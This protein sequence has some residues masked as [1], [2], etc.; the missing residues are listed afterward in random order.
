[1]NHITEEQVIE[2]AERLNLPS[3]PGPDQM[4]AIADELEST[5]GWVAVVWD[6][7]RI[8]DRL[9]NKR[10]VREREK[11]REEAKCALRYCVDCGAAIYRKRAI[12]CP[13]CAQRRHNRLSHGER[14]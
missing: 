10:A 3:K 8:G 1:M 14:A 11:K 9:R 5:Y 12:R 7:G 6:G 13:R 2:A 4:Q